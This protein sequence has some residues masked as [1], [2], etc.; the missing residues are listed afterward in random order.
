MVHDQ[1]MELVRGSGKLDNG[2]YE[3]A[4]PLQKGCVNMPNNRSCSKLYP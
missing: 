4:L 1:I 2:H 3:V